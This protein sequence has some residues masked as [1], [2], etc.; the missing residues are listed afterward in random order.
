MAKVGSVSPKPEAEAT[1]SQEPAFL[2]DPDLIEHPLVRRL[3]NLGKGRLH[4]RLVFA[5]AR[6]HE[7]GFVRSKSLRRLLWTVYGIRA[8]AFA[9]GS[10]LVPGNAEPGLSIGRYASIAQDV[11]WATGSVHPIKNIALT[12][13]FAQPDYGFVD[14]WAQERPT[15]EIEADAWIGSGVV[16]TD[17]CRR[18]GVGSIIGAGAVVTKDVPPFAVVVGVPARVL[19]FRFAEPVQE[20]I[21]ESRWWEHRPK[22][23]LAYGRAFR[24]MAGSEEA[25]SA[26]KALKAMREAIV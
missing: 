22:D 13:V 19:R 9:Y 26:L 3:V 21:L 18:V 11:R 2:S 7:G 1:A 8:E 16:I 14:S 15:L 6:R 10:L 24:S 23:L 4:S 17:S 20:A 25:L 5:L 12:P